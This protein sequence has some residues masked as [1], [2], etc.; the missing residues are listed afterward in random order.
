MTRTLGIVEAELSTATLKGK[1]ARKLGGK[2]LLEWVVRSATDSER[3]DQVVVVAR[4]PADGSALEE[5]VPPDVLLV[6][7]AGR[8]LL[9]RFACCL[10]EFPADAVVRMRADTPFVDP[11]LIDRLV[12]AADEHAACDYISYCLQDGRPA[13]SS[14][15]GIFADWIRGAALLRAQRAA[16]EAA[17]REQVT[18]YLLSHPETF[19]IRLLSV[20]A[21]LDRTDVRLTIDSEED[22]EH[23][24]VI[25]DALGSGAARLAA[26]CRPVEQPAGIARADGGVEPERFVTRARGARR[27]DSASHGCHVGRQGCRPA[28]PLAQDTVA[29]RRRCSPPRSPPA[30]LEYR[31]CCL[32][33]GACSTT[34]TLWH[35]WLVN[36][37]RRLGVQ[38]THRAFC[39]LWREEYLLDVHS[40]RARRRRVPAR[41]APQAS[42]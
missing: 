4:H 15:V 16:R 18:R 28:P 7:D 2:S 24:Q 35:R 40:G 32:K 9:D 10:A 6:H 23:A 34:T 11:V 37:L 31:A 29:V 5:L 33:R 14:P 21:E 8:D 13:I 19:N 38:T 12:S 1:V 30:S 26:D 3:L 42:D 27:K 17:D 22:W 20:P 41:V 36:L 25:F 39:R